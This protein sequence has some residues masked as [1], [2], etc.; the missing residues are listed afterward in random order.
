MEA[1]TII[2]SG[3]AGY[4]LLREFRRLDTTTP[5]TLLT[6]EDG[7]AYAKS[8]LPGSLAEGRSAADLVVASAEQ[9][10]HRHNARVM[11]YIRVSAIDR[12]RRVLDTNQG[13]MPWGRL[14]LAVGAE[15]LRPTA[16]GSG[17]SRILTVASLS[18]YAYLRAELA[19]RKH[20]TILGGPLWGCEFADDLARAGCQV[21]L[22]EPG[23]RLL[24]GLL[25]GLCARRLAQ[26]L[27]AAG[28]RVV[29]DEGA[30]RVDLA[31]DQMEV[32]TFGGA[33]IAADVVLAALG[34]RPRVSLAQ[35][36]GL[37]VGQGVWVDRQLRTPD[38]GIFA[39]GECAEVAGRPIELAADIEAAARV[40]AQ[41]LA[42]RAARLEWY[43][44]VRQLPL[45][46]IPITL[47]EPPPVVGEWHETATARGV[48][49]L[50]LDKQDSLRGF[51]LMG[52]AVGEAEKLAAR[53]PRPR[54]S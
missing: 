35:A 26:A 16:R 47:C 37:P 50:F 36:A 15:A 28:V 51:V 42:G 17:A 9:M 32:A 6:S 48:R 44:R 21:T 52:D 22:L 54:R 5:V 53:L 2:G 29:L 45:R 14:V 46:A 18:D 41:V 10:A 4:A 49:A 1:L 8:R 27:E 13:E 31:V 24:P 39:L 23:Q 11:P 34:S 40:L 33:V 19:G 43:P 30:R 38:P 7:A 20:V 12:T 3:L 25:P